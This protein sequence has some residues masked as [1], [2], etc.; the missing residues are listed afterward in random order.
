MDQP[1]FATLASKDR[2]SSTEISTTL[3][4]VKFIRLFRCELKRM[5]NDLASSGRN[6]LLAP[7]VPKTDG[8]IPPFNIPN[9]SQWPTTENKPTLATAASIV[10]SHYTGIEISL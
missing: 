9:I 5:P 4:S 6:V 7:S 8:A 1:A 2:D 10:P 3:S